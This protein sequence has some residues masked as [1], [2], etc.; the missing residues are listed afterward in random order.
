MISR[1]P[2]R[3][4][5]G[6]QGARTLAGTRPM[7]VT[8]LAA[9][10]ALFVCALGGF[11]STGRTIVAAP[12]QRLP[13]NARQLCSEHVSGTTMHI[14]WSSFAV[15]GTVAETRAFYERLGLTFTTESDGSLTHAPNAA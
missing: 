9:V 8:R 13:P 7:S 4:W 12:I 5:T 6:A 10:C 11:P 15:P 1:T 14:S 3:R 2:V